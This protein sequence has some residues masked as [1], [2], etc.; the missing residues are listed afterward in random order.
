MHPELGEPPQSTLHCAP[1]PHPSPASASLL[2]HPMLCHARLL[3]MWA[4]RQCCEVCKLPRNKAS[5][6]LVVTPVQNQ[7]PR[8]HPMNIMPDSQLPEYIQPLPPEPNTKP[9]SQ[10]QALCDPSPNSSASS[11]WQGLEALLTGRHQSLQDL[12]HTC[13]CRDL[14]SFCLCWSSMSPFL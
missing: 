9:C 11:R 13:R 14:C 4:Q 2:P 6:L 12:W 5:R 3:P 7:A 1:C 10:H 8:A